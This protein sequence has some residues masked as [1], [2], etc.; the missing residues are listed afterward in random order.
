MP[1]YRA[2]FVYTHIC[3]IFSCALI[4]LPGC[5]YAADLQEPDGLINYYDRFH[6]TI[7]RAGMVVSQNE[8][9]SEVGAQILKQGG[10][11]IDA[12]VATAFSLAV[13]LP[14]AGNL[15]GGGF[16]L[17]YLA[18]EDTSLTI[19][20]REVAP[21]AA[22][23]NMFLDKNSE[24]VADL[25]LHTLA[26]AGVPGTVAGLFYAHSNYG[27]LSWKQVI[28]PAEKLARQGIVFNDDMYRNFAITEGLRQNPESCRVYFKPGCNL[29]RPGDI[30]KQTDLANTLAYI[31]RHG[32]DGFYKGKIAKQIIAEMEKSGGLI[33][34]EDLANYQVEIRPAIRGTFNGYDIV[35]MPPP[36]S[37]GVHLVQMLNMFEVLASKDLSPGSA[38]LMHIQAEIFKRAYADRSK[39]LG[40]TDFVKVPTAGLTDKKY[41]RELAKTIKAGAI[42]PS[43]K[44]HPGK[45]PGYESPDT[46]H[47]SAVD[48]AGNVVSSTY[49][50]NHSF[51]SGITIPGTGM[52]MNN[53]MDDFVAK[54]GVPNSY[55]LVGGKANAIAPLKHPL[56]SMTPTIVFKNGKPFLATG[57][58]GGSKI[59]SAVF[60]QLVNVLF[61]DMNL[62][63]ATNAP[64]IHHQ[65]QPDV[66]YVEEGV[67]TD[68]IAL[69]KN[70]G[71][72]VELSKSLGSLQ[73]LMLKDGAALGAAD[74][75]RPHAKAV[76]VD[77]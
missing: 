55:G 65:W 33:S 49:T 16:M 44:I 62:A 59:I 40:D 30:F 45:P 51:G 42:T 28:K 60:Q 38:K 53:T 29:Y 14:R 73:S 17:L 2:N 10:N 50:L 72:K 68:S 76:A 9:A 58:P 22:S 47:F 39:Y 37:G 41:A 5:L 6:P 34:A 21:A 11:A 27:K 63:E 18:E 48:K 70:M 24:P 35:T 1:K 13:T 19:N 57:T 69:L 61:F 66:L 15:T 54:A 12:A 32:R 23:E 25:S 77:H 4:L 43:D 74:P 75:R 7:A 46:T 67:N 52:L 36:S 71:Y 64:R 26:A 20:Y 3:I 56:S 31:A 8:I